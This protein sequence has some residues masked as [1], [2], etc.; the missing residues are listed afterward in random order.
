MGTTPGS[1]GNTF[2]RAQREGPEHDMMNLRGKVPLTK[3]NNM[4]D[5]EGV[6]MALCHM[7][8]LCLIVLM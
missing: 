2:Q 5:R 8:C 3:V 4:R 6:V 7:K 1:S